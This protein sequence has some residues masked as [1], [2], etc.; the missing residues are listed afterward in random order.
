MLRNY[1]DLKVWQKSYNLCLEVYKL[2]KKFPVEERYGLSL[3]MRRSVVSVPSNVAEGYGRKSKQEYIHYLYV[4]YGSYCEFETQL[5]LAS[6]LD[7]IKKETFEKIFEL[8]REVERM[9]KALIDSLDKKP[10]K[11]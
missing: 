7:Y 10:L 8:A 4:A 2:L 6:D 5:L 1:Q 3:Q 9:L 11:P